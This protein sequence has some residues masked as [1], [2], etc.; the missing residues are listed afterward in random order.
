MGKWS[1]GRVARAL[2]SGGMSEVGSAITNRNPETGEHI[3]SSGGKKWSVNEAKKFSKKIAGKVETIRRVTNAIIGTDPSAV[4][5]N[6]KND[7]AKL[8]DGAKQIKTS[9]EERWTLFQNYQNAGWNDA[10]NRKD[11]K[12]HYD[13]ISTMEHDALAMDNKRHIWSTVRDIDKLARIIKTGNLAPLRAVAIISLRLNFMNLATIFKL[14]QKHDV[15]KYERQI[16]YTWL[17]LGGNRTQWDRAVDA[18]YKK[19][20]IA[21]KQMKLAE[22]GL[23]FYGTEGQAQPKGDNNNNNNLQEVK[24]ITNQIHNEAEVIRGNAPQDKKYLKIPQP[25]IAGITPLATAF[26]ATLGATPADRAASAS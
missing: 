16:K 19:K 12:F 26:G 15:N 13:K 21:A 6:H 2:L 25:V 3:G 8:T 20:P 1:L 14:A 7:F 22:I 5:P 4:K 11:G 17:R 9:T 24:R 10:N 18:G 23:N